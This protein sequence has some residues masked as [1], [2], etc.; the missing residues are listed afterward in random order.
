V[1][2]FGFIPPSVVPFQ[3]I[4]L[5][6]VMVV[7]GIAICCIAPIYLLRRHKIKN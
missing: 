4:F 3:S 1:I 7:L 6:E 2:L 5:Y